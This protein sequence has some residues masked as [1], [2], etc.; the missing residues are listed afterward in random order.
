MEQ[1]YASLTAFASKGCSLSY[2]ELTWLEK[3]EMI[4]RLI[5]NTSK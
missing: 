2:L 4:L 5:K 1:R 3:V